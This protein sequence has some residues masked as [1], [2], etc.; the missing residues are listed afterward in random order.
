MRLRRS[1]ATA[2]VA[3]SIATSALAGCSDEPDQASHRQTEPSSS[4]TTTVATVAGLALP[5]DL[6]TLLPPTYST[7]QQVD[8]DR[9]G[10]IDLEVAAMSFPG[11]AKSE[12]L[13]QSRARLTTAGFVRGAAVDYVDNPRISS[14]ALLEVASPAAAQAYVE[15]ERVAW[16]GLT[17]FERYWDISRTGPLEIRG[18]VK[19]GYWNLDVVYALGQVVVR[20]SYVAGPSRDVLEADYK[21]F[22]AMVRQRLDALPTD[23]H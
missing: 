6:G 12:V 16:Q 10:A 7:L 14:V 2:L 1:L 5:Q 11:S 20:E 9:T 8:S 4:T 23:P 18:Q 3:T 13:E 15:A 21:T 17:P 22:D 19:S